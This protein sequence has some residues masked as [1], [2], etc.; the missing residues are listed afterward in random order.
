MDKTTRENQAD[1]HSEIRTLRLPKR[2]Q[3]PN[4]D[5]FTHTTDQQ[6]DRR[7]D[8]LRRY[9]PIDGAN[10]HWSWKKQ[11]TTLILVLVLWKFLPMKKDATP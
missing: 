1:G 9:P 5:N 6:T 7:R 8:S 10:Y 11:I 2:W 4:F 3:T